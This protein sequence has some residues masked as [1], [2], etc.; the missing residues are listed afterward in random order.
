MNKSQRTAVMCGAI[1]LAVSAL[2]G[3]GAAQDRSQRG[4]NI[5]ETFDANGDGVLTQAEVNKVR[6]DRLIAFDTNADGNLTLEEYE[7]LWFDAM[8]ER[9]VDQFQGHDDD[10]DGVVT[11][12]EFAEPYS[13]V[14]ARMDENGDGEVT[15]DE[16]RRPQ[17]RER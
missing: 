13:G 4:M 10:G 2:A 15:R 7:A 17:R 5:F 8:Y 9:M 14:V 12:A 11:A 1:V 16:L 6:T 3:V